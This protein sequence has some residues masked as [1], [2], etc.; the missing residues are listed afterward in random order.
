MLWEPPRGSSSLHH[1]G[2]YAVIA[3]R[4]A[5]LGGAGREGCDPKT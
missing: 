2:D 3:G 5:D 1:A 4:V